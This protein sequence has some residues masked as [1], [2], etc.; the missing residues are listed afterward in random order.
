MWQIVFLKTVYNFAVSCNTVAIHHIAAYI[1][2]SLVAPIFYSSQ[3]AY[4]TFARHFHQQGDLEPP[5]HCIGTIL[6]LCSPKFIST[7]IYH[8]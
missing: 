4:L 1:P 5:F 7:L 8:R 2:L 3:E 6:L